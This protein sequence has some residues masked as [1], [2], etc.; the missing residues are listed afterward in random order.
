MTMT[1]G[2]PDTPPQRAVWCFIAATFV[3]ATPVIVFGGSAVLW[4]TILSL[5]AG[6]LL[7]VLGGVQL[8]RELSARKGDPP[9]ER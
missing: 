6:L 1:Q 7:V 4:V 2:R 5:A 9:S 3:F 8:G